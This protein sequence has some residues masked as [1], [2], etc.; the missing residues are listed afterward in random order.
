MGGEPAVRWRS[1]AFRSI[2]CSRTSAKS[3]SIS[4]PIGWRAGLRD[5]CHLGYGRD[6]VLDL[7]EAVRAQR[8]HALGDGD[9]ANCLGRGALDRQVADLVRDRHDLVEAGPSLVAG[10]AAAA[11]ADGLVCLEVEGHVE[12]RLL[13]RRDAQ[14]G[15]ALAV[16]AE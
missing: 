15:A 14:H 5:P 12:A 6:S 9:L 16:G 3:K 4:S 11:A 1:E 13:E 10:A 8:A 2:T 7:L